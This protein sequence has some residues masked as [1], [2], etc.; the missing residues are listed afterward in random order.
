MTLNKLVFNVDDDRLDRLLDPQTA[1]GSGNVNEPV[2]KDILSDNGTNVNIV[3]ST[4]YARASSGGTVNQQ[5]PIEF[6]IAGV[7]CVPYEFFADNS[8]INASKKDLIFIFDTCEGYKNHTYPY[9][10]AEVHVNYIMRHLTEMVDTFANTYHR[11]NNFDDI[12]KNSL[13]ILLSPDEIKNLGINRKTVNS[14]SKNIEISRMLKRSNVDIEANSILSI[15]KEAE[16]LAGKLITE[17]GIQQS[18]ENVSTNGEIDLS[19]LNGEQITNL[20]L[21]SIKDK[22]VIHSTIRSTIEEKNRIFNEKLMSMRIVPTRNFLKVYK[23]IDHLIKTSIRIKKVNNESSLII[24]GPPGVG[25]TFAVDAYRHLNSSDYAFAFISGD[26]DNITAY[27]NDLIGRNIVTAKNGGTE[28]EYVPGQLVIA[29]SDAIVNKKKALNVII[30]EFN[31]SASLGKLDQIIRDV[32]DTGIIRIEAQADMEELVNVMREKYGI[33]AQFKGG[34]IEIDT[35]NV[36][37]KGTRVPV[38]FTLIGNLPDK[39]LSASSLGVH[40]EIPAALVRRSIT[41]RLDYT[42]PYTKQGLDELKMVVMYDRHF[43][44]ML[45]DYVYGIACINKVNA[46]ELFNDV[47]SALASN[48]FSHIKQK[49]NEAIYNAIDEFVGSS[50]NSIIN[51]SLTFY[52]NLYDMYQNGQIKIV[53]SIPEILNHFSAMLDIIKDSATLQ[54]A[55]DDINDAIKQFVDKYVSS[56]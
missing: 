17:M 9:G 15:V 24:Y 51:Q 2:V 50:E 6:N 21:T 55:Q 41:R 49:Y 11:S 38:T 35:N 12:A 30:N 29:L 16:P 13:L 44:I 39:D 10:R 54:D 26:P 7:I 31:R 27:R 28:N 33:N 22:N 3:Y 4:I 52:N 48:D 40:E 18:K 36:D 1:T 43:N 25:K 14:I 23:E 47:M 37:G 53:P 34:F 19:L 45:E 46:T 32:G 56:K 20:I 8:L 5:K 42:N